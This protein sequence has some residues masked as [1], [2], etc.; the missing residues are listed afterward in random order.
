MSRN[1]K[2]LQT[3]TAVLVLLALYATS[4][5]HYLL[6]H[7]LAELF[8]V[9]V[10]VSLFIIA[11]NSRRYLHHGYLF[12]IGIAYLFVGFLDTLHMLGYTGMGVF[13]GYDYYGNQLWIAGRLVESLSL[14]AGFVY[15]RKKRIA[16]ELVLLAYTLVT[17]L[18]VAL[19]F[20]WRVFPACYVPDVGQTPFK[21]D[22]EFVIIGIL[23]VDI[24]VLHLNRKYF[25]KQVARWIFWSFILTILS[26]LS[27]ALYVD[28]YGILNMAGHYCKLF[29][30]YLLYKALVEKGIREPYELV[31][32]E[33]KEKE[34]HLAE[35][36]RTKDKFFSIIA[37]D[38]RNPVGGIYNLSTHLLESLDRTSAASLSEQI[39]LICQTSGRTYI[40]L[41]NLLQWARSQIGQIQ[42]EPVIVE[43]QSLVNNALELI[44]EKAKIKQVDIESDIEPNLLVRA[45]VNMMET[46]LRNLLS[47]AVKFSHRGGRV[48]GRACADGDEVLLS[49]I[50]RGT[51][52]SE[53]TQQELFLLDRPHSSFGTE[54][55]RGSG[56]GLVLC[57]EF[58]QRHGIALAVS[59]ELGSGSTFSLRLPA[60]RTLR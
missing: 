56:L 38:L 44:Q 20:W 52:M 43:V 28:N 15:I 58:L 12:F 18:F 53:K 60:A 30:F 39:A 25:E 34:E 41:D 22:M 27:F 13:A 19:V 9:C 45:D 17:L 51:G 31:Y 24:W 49:V 21:V 55:E 6:F 35:A 50:D 4:W 26:E 1:N 59:S 48:T 40:L 29:S 46:V 2:K 57:R 32:R 16:T 10:A 37:H 8:S 33:I 3:V 11:W 42:F 7:S 47:N 14:L 5:Y 54:D 23:L 36:L